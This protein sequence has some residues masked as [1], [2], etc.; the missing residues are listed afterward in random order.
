M[1]RSEMQAPRSIPITRRLRFEEI[2]VGVPSQ[3]TLQDNRPSVALQQVPA[4]QSEEKAPAAVTVTGTPII[5]PESSVEVNGTT[6]NPPE[7]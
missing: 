5:T 3:T 2:P 7:R 4:V 6:S 1:A